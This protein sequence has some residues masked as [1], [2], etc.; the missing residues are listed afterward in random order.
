MASSEE[1]PKKRLTVAQTDST[2]Q[3]WEDSKC[4]TFVLEGEDHTLGNALRYI[5]MKNPDVEFCGYGVPHPSENKINLRIQSRGPPAVEILKKGLLDL[6]QVCD[7]VLTTFEERVT[8][9]KQDMTDK[10][11]T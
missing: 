9:F 11:E 7:H 6:S 3:F 2:S 8:E 1:T 10:M 4:M 5:I